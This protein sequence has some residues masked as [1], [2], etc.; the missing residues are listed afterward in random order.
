MQKKFFRRLPVLLKITFKKWNDHDPFREG[1]VVAY[2]AI[3]ALPGSNGQ[4]FGLVPW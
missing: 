1:A 3:F 2:S 4:Q